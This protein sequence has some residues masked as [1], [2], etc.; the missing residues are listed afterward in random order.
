MPPSWRLPTPSRACSR[1]SAAG[2][3]CK[4]FY[5]PW[6]D[7]LCATGVVPAFSCGW[8]G[9]ASQEDASAVHRAEL[10]FDRNA[11]SP[12]ANGETEEHNV[13]QLR[14]VPTAQFAVRLLFMSR[15]HLRKSQSVRNPE[16][17]CDHSSI[18]GMPPG[19]HGLSNR[20]SRRH[21][22]VW[23]GRGD[24]RP[25][26]SRKR[27]ILRFEAPMVVFILG[28][29]RNSV[30]Q[31]QDNKHESPRAQGKFRFGVCPGAISVN[32]S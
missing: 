9:R 21:A 14:C 12:K 2:A 27:G 13:D 4:A 22:D 8:T 20:Q 30:G 28:E 11:K 5:V 32:T 26:G 7:G 25:N 3:R 31:P 1:G 18:R 23:V 24:R 29:T 17:G 6:H 19:V 16:P 10:A 15:C